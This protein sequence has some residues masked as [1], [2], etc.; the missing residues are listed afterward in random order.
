[1]PFTSCSVMALPA[2]LVP[3]V[4]PEDH[5]AAI[6]HEKLGVVLQGGIRRLIGL[7]GRCWYILTHID[8][9]ASAWM[10]L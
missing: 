2:R 10:P 7:G 1:M 3:L 9:S 4:A 5:A 6:G 8:K